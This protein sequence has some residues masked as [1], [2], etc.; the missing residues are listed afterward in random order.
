MEQIQVNLNVK[1]NSKTIRRET[2][3]GREH[4]VLPSYTL[5]SNVVMNGGLY[6][7]AEIEANYKKLDGTIAP[8]GHPVID[9][10]FVSAFDPRAINVNHIGAWN[11]NVKRVGERIYCEKW[12]DIEF[13]KNHSGGQRVLDRLEAIERGD[14]D[15][16]PIHTSVALFLERM[17]VNESQKGNGYDWVAKI[18][19]IDHD[20]I[21]LDEPGAAAPE[22]GVGLMVNADQAKPLQVNEGALGENSYRDKERR[23][24][25]AARARFATGDDEYV[26]I[27][28]FSDTKAV[29]IS[30]ASQ[31]VYDYSIVD[32]KVEFGSEGTPVVRRESWILSNPVIN[33]MKK[34]FSTQARPDNQPQEGDMPL[35]KEE[36]A[37]L[38]KQIGDQVSANTSEQLQPLIAK[39]DSLEANQK[40]I[41][42]SITANSKAAE[43]EKRKVVSAEY[44]EVIANS[45]SG[46]ALD[47][48]VEK[49][50]LA[51]GTTVGL[52]GNKADDDKTVSDFDAV[53]E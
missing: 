51:K 27:G 2:L 40:T 33:A 8:L 3:D 38:V 47:D 37:D 30:N 4:W 49:I 24:E 29:V 35:T 6:P 34:F 32:G 16:G 15:A 5:P 7:T 36:M 14:S 44:G 10:K 42:E 41:T 31:L 17:E 21:L 20:A 52:K 9:G 45:L 23:L 13:A 46:A 11:Q 48:M 22:Q 25:A 26:W 18:H 1:V 39:V 43:D 12:I 53:P 28:D 50:N 19:S